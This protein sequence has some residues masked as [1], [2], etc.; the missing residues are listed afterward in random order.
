MARH[1]RACALRAFRPAREVLRMVRDQLAVV[2][3]L[4]EV[5]PRFSLHRPIASWPGRSENEN[6]TV[7][8]LVAILTGTQDGTTK[9]SRGSK[10]KLSVPMVTWP[11]PSTTE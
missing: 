10:A 5:H 4:A 8:P 7:S 6:S 9:V 2:V 3:E 11:P 1:R